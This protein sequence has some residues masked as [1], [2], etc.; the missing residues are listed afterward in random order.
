MAVGGP[1]QAQATFTPN[2]NPAL[3]PQL[4]QALQLKGL[5][6]TLRKSVGGAKDATCV[7]SVWYNAKGS[8]LAAQLLRATGFPPVDQACLGTVIGQPLKVPE[9]LDPDEGGWTSFP[10]H[11]R[12]AGPTDDSKPPRMDADTSIPALLASGPVHVTAPYYPD[13]A[14][15][16]RAHGICRLHVTVSADGIVDSIEVTQSTGS[17]ALDQASVDAIYA[18]PFAPA[19]QDGKPAIGSTDIVLVWRLP[20]TTPPT[21]S[22]RQ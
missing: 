9:L 2:E 22:I 7:V 15:I 18:A 10:I 5:D 19:Q 4:T 3:S 11:W 12:F 1:A 14:L 20:V 21:G 6:P 16:S 13:A 8:I 17:A